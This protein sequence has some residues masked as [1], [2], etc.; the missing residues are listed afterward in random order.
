MDSNKKCF[1]CKHLTYREGYEYPYKCKKYRGISSGN[2]EIRD[3]L[4]AMNKEC[5][6]WEGRKND[7][8]D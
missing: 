8:T 3:Y 6:Q 1:N 4:K 7:G 2:S 5:K